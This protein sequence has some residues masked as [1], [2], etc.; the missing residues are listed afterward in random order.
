MDAVYI[1]TENCDLTYHLVI[2]FIVN[3]GF[4]IIIQ[5]LTDNRVQFRLYSRYFELMMQTRGNN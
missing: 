2:S 4:K 5:S 1:S 3:V